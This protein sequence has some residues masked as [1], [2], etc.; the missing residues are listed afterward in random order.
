MFINLFKRVALFW[1]FLGDEKMDGN[2][3]TVMGWPRVDSALEMGNS[4]QLQEKVQPLEKW[5]LQLWASQQHRAMVYPLPSHPPLHQQAWLPLEADLSACSRG[6]PLFAGAALMDV[7]EALVS[8]QVLLF[9]HIRA[10]RSLSSC[11][12]VVVTFGKG[13]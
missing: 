13:L 6:W 3:V 5:K 10:D 9:Q 8:S 7:F 11:T 12:H 1:H 4:R 2:V